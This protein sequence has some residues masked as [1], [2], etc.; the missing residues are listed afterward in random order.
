MTQQQ[1]STCCWTPHGLGLL[2]SNG[3]ITYTPIEMEADNDHAVLLPK[4]D[5]HTPPFHCIYLPIEQFLTRSFSL[6]LAQIRHL[7][8][9]ILG[10]ELADHAGINPNHWWLT[11]QAAKTDHGVAG[12]VFAIEKNLKHAIQDHPLWQ[13][14]PLIFMDAY[15]RLQYHIETQSAAGNIAVVDAD[16]D[17]V[18]FGYYHDGAWQGIRRLNADLNDVTQAK[19][20]GN[21]ILWSLQ[22]MGMPETTADHARSIVVLG[23]MNTSLAEHFSTLILDAEVMNGTLPSRIESNLQLPLPTSSSK[24]TLNIRH[25]KWSAQQSRLDVGIWQRPI[26]LAA[27]LSLLWFGLLVADNIRL[28]AQLAH[29]NTEITAAFQRGLPHQP[30]MIDALAQL[31]QAANNTHGN[32][33]GA[34]K[35]RTQLVAM[36]AVFN[37]SPWSM[38]ELKFEDKGTTMAGSIASLQRL[39]IVRDALAKATQADVKIADTD[40]SGD[41]VNFRMVW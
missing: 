26:I 9:D 11:W 3:A 8:A 30:V 6:P 2:A 34:T 21:Q 36:G 22:A 5:E 12:F 15:Q 4:L 20:I 29:I 18:F 25:G 32:T 35:I 10:Q 39:N 33:G 7:D 1:P 38:K 23:R 28:E 24:S 14:T 41:V 16:A 13:H 19:S 37:Q 17:G 40:L 31:R 27:S